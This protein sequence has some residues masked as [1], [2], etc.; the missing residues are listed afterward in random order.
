MNEII[1]KEDRVVLNA[2][3]EIFNNCYARVNLV[4]NNTRTSEPTSEAIPGENLMTA[5]QTMDKF[6]PVFYQGRN[7][8]VTCGLNF[9]F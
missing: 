4:Y 8:T 3:Y 5:Q 6:T 1:W 2:V 7:I 9:G